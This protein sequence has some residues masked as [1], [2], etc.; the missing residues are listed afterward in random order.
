MRVNQGWVLFWI[1]KV[2]VISHFSVILSF[3]YI[4]ISEVTMENRTW[5]NDLLDR[6][7]LIKKKSLW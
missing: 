3:N 1:L 2:I 4:P 7:K 5:F 6:L